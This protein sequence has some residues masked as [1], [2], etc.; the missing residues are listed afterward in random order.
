MPDLCVAET[1]NVRHQSD[2]LTPSA[3]NR[4]IGAVGRVGATACGQPDAIDQAELDMRYAEWGVPK[5][6]RIRIADLPPCPTC[7]PAE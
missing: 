1:G 7:F 5:A 6:G 3:T 4:L 2:N